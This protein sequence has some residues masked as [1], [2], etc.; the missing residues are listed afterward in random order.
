MAPNP[1]QLPL[2]IRFEVGYDG[3][4]FCGWQ[5]QNHGGRPSVQQT[6]ET[7]LSKIFA[8]KI[9]LSASGRT[10]AGVHALR[11]ICHFDVMAPKERFEAWNM[12]YALARYLPESIVVRKVWLAP[13]DF[14]ST[15]SATH[16]TYRY[17]IWNRPRPSAILHRYTHWVRHPLAVERLQE[18]AQSFLG[19]HDFKTFQ[20]A[21]TPIR[22]TVR[23]IFRSE[24]R[25]R[26]PGLLEY[27]ITGSGFLK[28]MV[29]NIVGAQLSLHK[30]GGGP[31]EIAALF[32]AMDRKR[33]PA[34]APA[35]GLF[36][37]RVYYPRNLDNQCREL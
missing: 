3:T 13:A 24:W 9:S 15:L 35:Q 27:R 34:P 23:K 21:G 22:H 11:Q 29:R 6:L 5:R 28:Q 20:S 18:L 4:D 33:A 37:V 2:R 7:A 25:E 36:L 32:D 10:D 17:L 31:Q 12:P 30:S 14:H 8:Q 16:K 26:K 1:P 19:S